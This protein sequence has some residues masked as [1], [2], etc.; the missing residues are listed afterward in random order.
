MKAA[1]DANK[2]TLGE[3]T[4]TLPKKEEIAN[5]SILNIEGDTIQPNDEISDNQ[6]K[7]QE[8]PFHEPAKQDSFH[9]E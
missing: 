1:A 3:E 9:Q 2:K 7:V 6:T 8:T 4:T 5:V